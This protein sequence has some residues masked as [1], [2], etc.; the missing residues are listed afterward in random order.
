MGTNRQLPPVETCISTRLSGFTLLRPAFLRATGASP[1][2]GGKVRDCPR[3][4]ADHI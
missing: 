2:L 1:T 4:R 3:K